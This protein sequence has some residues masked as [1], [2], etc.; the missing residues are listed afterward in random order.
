MTLST[1]N[2][3]AKCP[4]VPFLKQYNPYCVVEGQE[5]GL[6]KAL[7]QDSPRL[8]EEGG[9]ICVLTEALVPL[10]TFRGLLRGQ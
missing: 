7:A 2:P 9:S 4:T 8:S 6:R 1:L 10:S 3:V 5:L